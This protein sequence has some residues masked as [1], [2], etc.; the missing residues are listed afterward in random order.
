M[1]DTCF[2]W[3]RMPREGINNAALLCAL[4]ESLIDSRVPWSRT[5]MAGT[6]WVFSVSLL[7][8]AGL[9]S[10]LHTWG[11]PPSHLSFFTWKPLT[12]S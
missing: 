8:F 5:F 3:S 2:I 7:P 6:P 1:G 9:D 11:L 12:I 4:S 10:N